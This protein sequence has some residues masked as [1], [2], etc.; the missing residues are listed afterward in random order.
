[1]VIS[2]NTFGVATSP[3]LLALHKGAPNENRERE[4]E[5]ETGFAIE[6]WGTL[7][8]LHERS[9]LLSGLNRECERHRP[10]HARAHLDF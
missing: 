2:C 10:T 1:M 3:K 4:R 6:V 5:R 9:L 8:K 7:F